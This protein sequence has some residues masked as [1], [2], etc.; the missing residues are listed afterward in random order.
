M[1][2]LAELL[3]IP[4]ASRYPALS[5]TPQRQ[6]DKTFAAL[7]R[8]VEALA[9][10]KPLLMIFEDAH[11]SDPTS[12]DLLHLTVEQVQ[13][14]PVLLLVTSSARTPIALDRSGAR[15]GDDAKPSQPT[16]RVGFGETYQWRDKA[17]PGEVI[18]EIVGRG[19]GVPLFVEEL[20]KALLEALGQAEPQPNR[21]STRRLAGRSG[22]RPH[23]TVRS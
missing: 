2:L 6:K 12:R 20:T 17:L 18:D 22:C 15:H 1:A 11:W 21:P 9:D 7:L 19:D 10:E 14:L 8:Q 23:C 13:H 4:T 5:L 3:S 16:R